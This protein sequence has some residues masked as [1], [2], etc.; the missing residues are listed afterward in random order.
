MHR[1]LAEYMYVSADVS[2]FRLGGA[3]GV[4]FVVQSLGGGGCFAGFGL[5]NTADTPWLDPRL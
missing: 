3:A 1:C 2:M 5:I 4:L